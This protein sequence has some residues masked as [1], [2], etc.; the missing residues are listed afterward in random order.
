M[1]KKSPGFVP[2]VANLTHFESK[3]DRS[4][5][6]VVVDDVDSQHFVDN[7]WQLTVVLC[8]EMNSKIVFTITGVIPT[9][10]CFKTHFGWVQSSLNTATTVVVIY[11]ASI[12]NLRNFME[13]FSTKLY[14]WLI[15]F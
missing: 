13:Y 15:Y 14:F 8:S 1:E 6:I 2:F 3:F 7:C 4:E 10:I 5:R 9:D 12:L 11:S